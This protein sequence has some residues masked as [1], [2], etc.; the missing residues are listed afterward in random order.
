M[1]ALCA[2]I[3]EEKDHAIFVALLRDLS[4]LLE[5][6][7]LRLRGASVREWPWNRPWK[8]VPGIVKKILKPSPRSSKL[9]KKAGRT[10]YREFCRLAFPKT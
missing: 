2:R 6:K 10:H 1:N 4:D 3:Q 9:W 8:T 5:R 7:E